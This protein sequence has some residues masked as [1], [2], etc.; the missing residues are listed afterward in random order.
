MRI[1]VVIPTLD[2][3]LRIATAIEKAWQSGADEVIVVDGGSR[4]AT[5]TIADPLVTQV[6]VSD[7]GRGR[8]L[9]SG[10]SAATGDVFMFCHAD[11]WL[12]AGGCD[13]IR[14]AMA[15]QPD[16]PD[17]ILA[18]GGGFRQRIQASGLLYRS[19]EC[20]NGLRVRLQRLVYGDQ[21]IFVR[22]EHFEACGGFAD[23]PLME[24]FD[25]S[26]RCFAGSRP[27]LLDGPLF[28]DPRRWEQRGVVGTTLEN[29]RIASAWRKGVDAQTLYDR[30]Y[31]DSGSPQP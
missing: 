31:R 16:K 24:D 3:A 20:G 29:W 21:G 19:L 8:Q 22:R 14:A 7:P 5:V 9:N 23:L 4:D 17:E 12:V 18:V 10:A 1:S 28:I 15:P 6:L 13:Q 11:N 27:L 25:F 30:Y 26:Q 2:E